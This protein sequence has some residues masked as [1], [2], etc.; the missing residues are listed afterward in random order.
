M[1][2]ACFVPS[3]QRISGFVG[4][5][6][7]PQSKV[8]SQILLR[9]ITAAAQHFLNLHQIA[10]DRGHADIQGEPIA[11]CP[12]Q[13]GVDP[14]ICRTTLRRKNHRSD[15]EIFDDKVQL[16]VVK[17]VDQAIPRVTCSS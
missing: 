12:L 1:V 6:M 2:K 14:A 8:D 11:F 16:S 17:Q 15:F 9:Q 3:G 4:T 13:L 10:C 5:L 7:T